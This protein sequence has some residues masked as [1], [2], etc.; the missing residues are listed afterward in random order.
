MAT[1]AMLRIFKSCIYFWFS[2]KNSV[3]MNM[4]HAGF[5]ALVGCRSPWYLSTQAND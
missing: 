1:L 5:V 4:H 2:F 3:S